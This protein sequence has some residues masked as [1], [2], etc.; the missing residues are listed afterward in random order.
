MIQNR[1]LRL[2]DRRTKT[3]ETARGVVQ[4]IADGCRDPYEG[5]RELYGIYINSSGA[6]AE[7]QPL[8]RL[9]GI[10]PDGSIRVDDSFRR[11]VVAAAV[12]WLRQNPQ[13]PNT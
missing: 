7:L 3:I 9:P 6:V 4:S 8:F 10:E 5:Y 11:T 13:S 12:D 1:R 2:A